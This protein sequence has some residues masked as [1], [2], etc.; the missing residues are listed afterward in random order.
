MCGSRVLT[1]VA[2]SVLL[3]AIVSAQRYKPLSSHT[4]PDTLVMVDGRQIRGLIL[5]NTADSV[6]LQTEKTEMLVPKSDIRRISDEMEGEVVFA[7]VAKPGR[8]PSWRAMVF[9]LR[10]HDSIYALEQIPATRIEE[11][12]LKNIPYLSFR[13]NEQSEF[14]IYG[15]PND[16]VAIEFGMYG[17]RRKDPKYQ[18]MVREFLAGHLQSREQIA[19]LYSLPLQG[20]EKKVG[21]MALKITPPSE[22]DAYGGWWISIYNPSRV[23]SSRVGDAAYAAVTKP[24][25]EINYRD[26]RLRR[27]NVDKDKDWLASLVSRMTGTI[28]QV[29]GFYRDKEGVFRLISFGSAPQAAA[30]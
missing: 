1:A 20:G 3:P 23:A 6:L 27:E 15:D 29:R 7:D 9:D 5:K 14:N 21:Q 2:I 22:A 12:Y 26:G 8:L 16:P 25:D 19:A 4:M 13:V 24:F 18:R 28:P 11:G 10:N 30:P 17:A